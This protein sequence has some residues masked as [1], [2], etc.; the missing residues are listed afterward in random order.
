M[1][2]PKP[3]DITSWTIAVVSQFDDASVVSSIRLLPDTPRERSVYEL[4]SVRATMSGA[5]TGNLAS[6]GFIDAPVPVGITNTDLAMMATRHGALTGQTTGNLFWHWGRSNQIGAGMGDGT[7]Y[8]PP[9]FLYD[10]ELHGIWQ[11][12]AGA[13]IEFL[14][15]CTYRVWTFSRRDYIALQGKLPPGNVGKDRQIST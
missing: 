12:G 10:G 15:T 9:K 2:V 11:N 5:G 8:L 14:F 6:M 1:G 13:A 4:H 7:I 3:I